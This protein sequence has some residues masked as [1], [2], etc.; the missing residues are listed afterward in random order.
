MERATNAGLTTAQLADRTGLSAGTLRMWENR[1]GFPEPTRLPGGHRRYSQTDAELVLE[2]LRLRDGGLSLPA[3]I[4]RARQRQR[5]PAASIFAGLRR[6]RPDVPPVIMP[7]RVVL[8]MTRAIEDEY[9]ARAADGVLIGSFQRESFYRK[10]ERRW[11]EL[12]R[13]AAVSVALAD[14][15]SPRA[16][17]DGYV[18]VAVDRR[19]ALAREWSIVIAAANA[20]AC[21]AG[22]EQPS[23]DEMPDSARRF[24]V[25]WSFDPSVVSEALEVVMEIIR[26]LDPDAADAVRAAA[27]A[28]V[29]APASA[30]DYGGALTQRMIG[31]LG[32]LV[33]V[34][35][36]MSG[37]GVNP[38]AL[39][40]LRESQLA[41]AAASDAGAAPGSPSAASCADTAASTAS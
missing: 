21:L 33:S 23:Q 3:A 31:Y 41:R 10:N 30:L 37:I 15:A 40:S 5:P 11:D 20:Q 8:A 9:C 35:G 7:K 4:D 26:P 13:T 12:R 32:R 17:E 29:M 34:P 22:W 2:V 27:T 39:S 16:L 24:E 25:L 38:P 36:P 1:H 28:P 18:E 6:R 14:F 19:H